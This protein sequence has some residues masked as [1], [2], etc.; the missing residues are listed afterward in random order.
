MSKLVVPSTSKS[1]SKS[2]FPVTFS[3]S[4]MYIFLAILTP[5]STL[6]APVSPEASVASWVSVISTNPL[7]VDCFEL[8]I[9]SAVE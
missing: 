9:V 4:P 8:L 3:V 5:P 7:K 6:K 2:A 1:P